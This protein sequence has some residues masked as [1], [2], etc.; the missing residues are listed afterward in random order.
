MGRSPKRVWDNSR[1]TVF[2]KTKVRRWLL[3]HRR[4]QF[5][6]SRVSVRFLGEADPDH[7]PGPDATDGEARNPGHR[8][9]KR[10]PRSMDA[11]AKRLAWNQS[12]HPRGATWAAIRSQ[13][14]LSILH[15]NTQGLLSSLP[16]L[17]ARI[18]LMKDKPMFVR[19]NK[20]FLDKS[21]GT[22]AL[23][24]YSTQLLANGTAVNW[25][26]THGSVVESFYMLP[27]PT[28]PMLRC[29]VNSERLWAMIHSDLGP[30]L[31][32]VW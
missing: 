8:L 11:R 26:S 21:V 15:V 28:S 19:I 23:E 30:Y 12:N 13:A 4:T 6:E 10:G 24:G 32:C 22:V 25:A 29:S 9:R 7:A 17:T 31:L 5:E 14:K 20:T 3:R 27:L 18:R 1:K 2:V 16:E